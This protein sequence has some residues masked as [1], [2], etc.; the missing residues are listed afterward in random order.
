[1]ILKGSLV[2]F[3][4]IDYMHWEW[5][6]CLVSWQGQYQKIDVNKSIILGA[7]ANQSLWICHAYFGMLG[8]N[9]DVNVLDRSPLVCNTLQVVGDDI[10]FVLNGTT[11]PRY[12]LLANN[13]YPKWAY[14]VQT[15]HGPPN[16]KH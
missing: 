5:K 13:I 2:C 11:Y 15:I 10:H 7:V 9:N 1:M 6:N 12:Y 3:A 16:E 8:S 4:S 14:F